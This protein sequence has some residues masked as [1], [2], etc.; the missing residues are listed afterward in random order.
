MGHKIRG[1]GIRTDDIREPYS[2]KIRQSEKM[3]SRD[4]DR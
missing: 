2:G 3:Y 1:N 4:V